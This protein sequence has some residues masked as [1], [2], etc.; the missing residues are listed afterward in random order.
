MSATSIIDHSDHV[1]LLNKEAVTEKLLKVAAIYSFNASGKSNVLEALEHMKFLVKTLFTD[2][3]KRKV[4]LLKR[5]SSLNFKT[6][7]IFSS[8]VNLTLLFIYYQLSY[9]Y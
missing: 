2:A 6:K 1:I 9:F 8:A 7:N 4:I 3:S 5:F